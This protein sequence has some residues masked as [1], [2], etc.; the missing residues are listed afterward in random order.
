[1]EGPL[2]LR[3]TD[4]DDLTVVA[5]C[6]QDALVPIGDMTFLPEDRRFVLVANRFRWE[7]GA[8]ATDL[9]GETDSGADVSYDSAAGPHFE[10]VN[11]GVWFDG[12][13]SV[14]TKGVD[15]RDRSVI[16]ELLTLRRDGGH[17]MMMFAGGAT[18]Q[19]EIDG[20]RC[21]L[22]DVGEPWPTRWRPAHPAGDA[23]GPGE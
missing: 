2:K 1:M 11:C 7:A 23:E 3:A 14:R 12:V 5:T 22:E 20:L 13:K 4:Q 19:L 8:S 18:I 6:L 10:R 21:F 17:L 16:L 9:P 15:L